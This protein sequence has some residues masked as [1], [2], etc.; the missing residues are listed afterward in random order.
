MFYKTKLICIEQRTGAEEE[1]Y[2]GRKGNGEDGYFGN[3]VIMKEDCPRCG[4]PHSTKG[5]TLPC[6]E[7]ILQERLKTDMI[8]RN[9]V[10]D[11]VDKTL[12]CFCPEGDKCHGNILM[13][14]IHR[15]N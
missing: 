6:Y 5:S 12:V 15:L 13:D 7:K 4:K 11:L 9:R 2:I 14:Y 8:F 1:V 10:K 3:P